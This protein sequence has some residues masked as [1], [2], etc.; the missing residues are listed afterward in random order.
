MIYLHIYV[1]PVS[2]ISVFLNLKK[3]QYGRRAL[4]NHMKSDYVL[5]LTTGIENISENDF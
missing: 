4:L 2:I 3:C 5:K 1:Y